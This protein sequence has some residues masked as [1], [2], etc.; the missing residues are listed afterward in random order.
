MRLR[1]SAAS[2]LPLQL[3]ARE[4]VSPSIWL[5]RQA[6]RHVSEYGALRASSAL[7]NST[8]YLGVYRSLGVEV[9]AH[10]QSFADFAL[11]NARMF[12]EIAGK[13]RELEF[14]SQHKSRFVANMSH[15]L[16]TPPAAILGYPELMQEGFYEP[17]AP[18]SLDASFELKAPLRPHQNRARHC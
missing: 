18:K 8:Q 16:R 6:G 17:Q 10:L 7:R 3:F 15:E 9:A 13:S 14:A 2:L 5:M 11:K 1:E 12:E 4:A